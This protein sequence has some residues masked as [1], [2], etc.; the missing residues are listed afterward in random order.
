T[1]RSGL[2]CTN[3]N[4]RARSYPMIAVSGSSRPAAA[5]AFQRRFDTRFFM[6]TPPRCE[7]RQ[8]AS[9]SL[10]SRPS[11]PQTTARRQEYQYSPP[12][13]VYSQPPQAPR[14]SACW[15]RSARTTSQ[16][17][18]LHV[19]LVCRWRDD[20]RAWLDLSLNWLPRDMPPRQRKISKGVSRVAR[21]VMDV[22]CPKRLLL[23]VPLAPV[24]FERRDPRFL[25][26][27]V[28]HA[29]RQRA[30]HRVD[31]VSNR[32]HRH[33]ERLKAKSLHGFDACPAAPPLFDLGIMRDKVS[34]MPPA[35]LVLP[36]LDLLGVMLDANAARRV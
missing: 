1:S 2:A 12:R 30:P 36:L 19:A 5:R 27:R 4:Q 35:M 21:P 28:K 24:L 10:P 14:S 23:V 11:K 3:L 33:Q 29:Q 22:R 13:P 7:T 31:P 34:T 18:P 16:P 9:A 17:Q 20:P 32:S 8:C 6:S 26:A 25:C 15:P